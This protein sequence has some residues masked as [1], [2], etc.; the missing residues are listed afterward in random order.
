MKYIKF[1]DV[2]DEETVVNIAQITHMWNE[3][4]ED[5]GETITI[6]K[7]GLINGREVKTKLS[8][9]DILCMI[10]DAESSM[11]Y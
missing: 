11:V 9:D 8:L 7:I 10:T 1:I 6:T 5:K 2:Y 4:A 3:K